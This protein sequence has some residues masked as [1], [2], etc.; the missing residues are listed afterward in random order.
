[1]TQKIPCAHHGKTVIQL[2]VKKELVPPNPSGMT[3]DTIPQSASE[4]K[5]NYG[6]QRFRAFYQGLLIRKTVLPN[7]TDKSQA[8]RQGEWNRQ[9]AMPWGNHFMVTSTDSDRLNNPAQIAAMKQRQLA[10]PSSY[11]QF[12]AFMHAL[13]AAFGTIKSS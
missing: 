9:A 7:D 5:N 6:L 12:Y 2:M 4:G 10:P 3:F 8:Y 1:M 13:S 11:G